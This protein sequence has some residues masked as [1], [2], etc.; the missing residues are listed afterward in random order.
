MNLNVE[1]AL[2]VEKIVVQSLDSL[3]LFL[4][5]EEGFVR[6]DVRYF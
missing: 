2:V 6:T 5:V 4:H 1:I 3:V